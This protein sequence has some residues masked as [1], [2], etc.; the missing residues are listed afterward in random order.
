MSFGAPEWLWGLLLVPLLIALFLRA[1]NRGLDRLQQFVSA[2][3]LP[4][5]AGTVNRPR[6]IMSCGLQLLGLAQAI[7]S[8]APPRWGYTFQHVTRKG[9]VLLIALATTRSIAHND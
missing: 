6:R 4:Q 2:R 9:L 8:M 1:E 5:L 7:V 3:L